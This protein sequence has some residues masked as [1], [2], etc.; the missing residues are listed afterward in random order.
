[1]SAGWTQIEQTKT[2]NY[3]LTLT[4]PP[5]KLNRYAPKLNRYAYRGEGTQIEPAA[6]QIVPTVA[7]AR[8]PDEMR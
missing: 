1:M 5:P 3:Q 6:P 4:K 7:S 2:K 8:L